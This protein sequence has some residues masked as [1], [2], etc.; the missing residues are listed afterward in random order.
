[1]IYLNQGFFYTSKSEFGTNGLI[2]I[3]LFSG[4]GEHF[5][6]VYLMYDYIIQELSKKKGRNP[7]ILTYASHLSMICTHIPVNV[8]DSQLTMEKPSSIESSIIQPMT[9]SSMIVPISMDGKDKTL[10]LSTTLSEVRPSIKF[11]NGTFL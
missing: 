7:M 5:N 4:N 8:K 1:L 10:T 2:H 6:W 9:S 3:G 11:C